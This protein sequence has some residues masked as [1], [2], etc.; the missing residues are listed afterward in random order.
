MKSSEIRDIKGIELVGTLKDM[1]KQLFNMRSQ[2]MT[3]KVENF[4]AVGNLRR[5]I[6]RIKTIIR[7]IELKD[8]KGN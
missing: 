5:D 4:K 1:Q 7:E 6:A 3:E 8:S 2:S